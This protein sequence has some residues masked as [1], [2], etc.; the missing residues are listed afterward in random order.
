[1]LEELIAVKKAIKKK[2]SKEKVK[3]KY[4][5]YFMAYEESER[6]VE[7]K[8]RYREITQ[9]YWNYMYFSGRGRE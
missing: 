4:Q 9:K 2:E 1:M 5:E 7:D 6:N 8:L 3:K